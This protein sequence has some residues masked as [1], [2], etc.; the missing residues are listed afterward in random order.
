[1]DR[2]QKLLAGLIVVL[3]VVLAYRLLNPYEQPTVDSLTYTGRAGVSA[4]IDE[5]VPTVSAGPGVERLLSGLYGGS[6]SWT[7][8]VTRNPFAKP[9]PMAAATE[10]EPVPAP[11]PVQPVAT[12]ED[13]VREALGQFQAFGSFVQGGER[14][15]FLQR[16]KQV[17]LVRENDIIDG[18]YVVESFTDDTITVT[19]ADMD[20]PVT[21]GLKEPPDTAGGRLRPATALPSS[22]PAP[23]P[24]PED[25]FAP[26][27]PPVE[28]IP[29]VAQD[30]TLE[31]PRQDNPGGEEDRNISGLKPSF[32]SKKE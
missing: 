2:S 14:V 8:E 27:E 7:A 21:V 20:I 28:E 18:R 26:E 6:P 11:R 13:R 31:P 29:E 32:P 24:P 10:A 1:M 30:E 4:R 3:V 9:R 5:A 22:I 16:G 19:G 25:D 17:I 23:E 15:L 12:A